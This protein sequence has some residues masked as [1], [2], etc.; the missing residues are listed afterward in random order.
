MMKSDAEA[1]MEVANMSDYYYL[2]ETSEDAWKHWRKIREE[3]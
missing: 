1:F 2:K 3:I